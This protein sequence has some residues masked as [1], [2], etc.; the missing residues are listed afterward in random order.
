MERTGF[1]VAVKHKN[2]SV[3]LC[4]F[5]D[6]RGEAFINAAS[7]RQGWKQSMSRITMPTSIRV[8]EVTEQQWADNNGIEL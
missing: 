3:K 4:G 6:T 2:E 1:T 7:L 8:R 5:Y